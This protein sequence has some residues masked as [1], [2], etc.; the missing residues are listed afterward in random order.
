MFQKWICMI[1]LVT[2]SSVNIPSKNSERKACRAVWLPYSRRIP[3]RSAQQQ[4]GEVN[5]SMPP[6]L[7]PGTPVADRGMCWIGLQEVQGKRTRCERLPVRGSCFVK[8]I[9]P[10]LSC[11]TVQLP[12]RSTFEG[13]SDSIGEV[14]DRASA[15]HLANIRRTRHSFPTC[16][17]FR[18]QIWHQVRWP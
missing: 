7:A 3:G 14:A 18:L 4:R 9:L 12:D 5:T 2:N 6:T 10:L 11:S 1:V 13:D 16:F 8:R 17:S 15:A